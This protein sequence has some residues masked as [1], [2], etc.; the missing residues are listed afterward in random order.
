MI[1]EDNDA[2]S[3]FSA[4]N[5]GV[6]VI[7]TRVYSFIL[8]PV[9]SVMLNCQYLMGL[10]ECN[11]WD[12]HTCQLVTPV[13]SIVGVPVKF[14]AGPAGCPWSVQLHCSD[15]AGAR[16]WGSRES[17]HWTPA[18]RGAGGWYKIW[19][20]HPGKCLSLLLFKPDLFLGGGLWRLHSNPLLSLTGHPQCE[21]TSSTEWGFCPL[22]GFSQQKYRLLP[23]YLYQLFKFDLLLTLLLILM[24]FYLWSCLCGHV[25]L[26]LNSDVLI[27]GAKLRNRAVHGDMVVIELLPRNEWKGRTMALTEGQ[28][29]EQPL[30]E[31]QSQPMPSGDH[32]YMMITILCRMWRLTDTHEDRWMYLHIRWCFQ[33]TF[34]FKW[35]HFQSFSVGADFWTSL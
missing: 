17:V 22:W 31:T 15:P 26:E 21:Q 16:E 14:L 28:G 34:R 8:C 12:Q 35:Q 7:S 24:V 27:N 9:K 3:E 1:T 13:N 29:E 32:G 23:T 5:S 6:Y 25:F 19:Q 30:E 20:V 2:I 11:K 33:V 10:N 4:L 18:C